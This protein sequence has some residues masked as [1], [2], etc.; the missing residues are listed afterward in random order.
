[1]SITWI[2]KSVWHKGK[3]SGIRNYEL[4]IRETGFR[5]QKSGVGIQN[6]GAR[7]KLVIAGD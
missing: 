4:G 7:S 1:M 5:I 2:I 3:S 6:R